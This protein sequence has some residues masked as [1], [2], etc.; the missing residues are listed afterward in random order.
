MDKELNLL[1]IDLLSEMEM[2]TELSQHY[3][4]DEN[5]IIDVIYFY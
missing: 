1:P 4:D 3:E 5:E 2:D